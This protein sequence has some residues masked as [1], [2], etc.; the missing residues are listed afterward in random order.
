LGKPLISDAQM[1]SIYKAMLH[2]HRHQAQP[3]SSLPKQQRLQLQQQWQRQPIA[4]L[5]ATL[6]QLRTEDVLVTQGDQPWAAEV[7]ALAYAGTF[8]PEVQPTVLSIPNPESVAPLAAG[9]ALA[10]SRYSHPGDHAPVT[11]ALLSPNASLDDAMRIA[12]QS[13]L[14]LILIILEDAGIPATGHTPKPRLT[15]EAPANVEL[16]LID[17]LDAVACCRVM[18][19]SLLRARNR[20]GAV[21]LQA[22]SLPGTPGALTQIEAHLQRRNIALPTP[23]PRA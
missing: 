13:L 19:E 9:Y 18:Q 7:V 22:V 6:L 8:S 12:G 15:I 10:Q 17:A 23:A 14:P 4:L 16:I 11:V 2:L 21:V 3:N 5:A 20:W 1:L